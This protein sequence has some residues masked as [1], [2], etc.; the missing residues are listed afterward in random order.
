MRI[1]AMLMDP[2]IYTEQGWFCRKK[3]VT[4]TMMGAMSMNIRRSLSPFHAECEAL[5]WTIEC[6]KTLYISEV[7]FATYCCPLLKMVS[8]PIE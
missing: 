8:T 5:I 4:E 7:V 6:M 1:S 3:G 2:A